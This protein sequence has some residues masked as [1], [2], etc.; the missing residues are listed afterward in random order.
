ML[1]PYL[2]AAATAVGILGD[3]YDVTYTT[4]GLKKGLAV[5]GNTWLIGNKPSEKALYLRDGL[6]LAFCMLPTILG[7][8]VFHNVPVAYGGLVSPV[9]YG[10]KHYM[11]GLAWKKLGA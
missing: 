6:V 8:T 9:I 1:L 5:E 2:F 3:V 11:G 10:V 4:I 7:A